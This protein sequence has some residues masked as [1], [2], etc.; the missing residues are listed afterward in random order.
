MP[1]L[2]LV[3]L[4]ILVASGSLAI[5]FALK[6]VAMTT[7]YRPTFIG[8]SPTDYATITAICFGFA[9]VLVART[10]LK[11]NEPGMLQLQSRLRAEEAHKRAVEMEQQR[12]LTTP[13]DVARPETS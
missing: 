11:L 7:V 10:W 8:F 3:D 13:A 1:V 12:G 9:L 4:L 2:P 5:G 6:M